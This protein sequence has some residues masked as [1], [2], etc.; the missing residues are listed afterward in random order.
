M[1]AEGEKPAPRPLKSAR[2]ELKVTVN[3]SKCT[4]GRGG[5]PRQRQVDHR[6]GRGRLWKGPL[7]CAA[8]SWPLPSFFKIERDCVS[9]RRNGTSRIYFCCPSISRCLNH[10]LWYGSDI[11]MCVPTLRE[12]PCD[13]LTAQISESDILGFGSQ[14]T[15]HLGQNTASVFPVQSRAASTCLP[16]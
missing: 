11:A 5:A 4:E 12:T 3:S 8:S 9:K 16:G 13:M 7:G 15:Y 6:A 10:C 2:P 14:L 1:S